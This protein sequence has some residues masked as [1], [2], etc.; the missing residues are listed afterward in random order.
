MASWLILRLIF[1][2]CYRICTFY[3]MCIHAYIHTIYGMPYWT[4]AVCR[5]I[6]SSPE[7]LRGPPAAAPPASAPPPESGIETEA[8]SS[9]RGNWGSQLEFLLS[10]LSYAVGLGNIWRFPYL[11]YQNGGGVCQ[12]DAFA[13]GGVGVRPKT[14]MIYVLCIVSNT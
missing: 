3:V 8:D 2:D 12:A 10:C 13:A 11:C 7:Q 14:C 9:R 4:C 6:Q 1:S 5:Q